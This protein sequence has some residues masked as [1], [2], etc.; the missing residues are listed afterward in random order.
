MI[1][2]CR[3]T[4]IAAVLSVCAWAQY[5]QP[6][7]DVENP[8]RTPVWGYAS[9][10]IDVGWVNVLLDVTTVASGQRLVLEYASV[11]C[12]TDADDNISRVTISIYKKTPTGWTSYGVPLVV[13]KQGN[14]YDG[15]ASFSVSQLVRLYSDGIGNT[16]SID[17]RHSKTTATASCYAVVN[18]Y[19]LATP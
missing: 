14:T 3:V 16:T 7:R 19:T 18:G 4:L 9:G 1:R 11:S 2:V 6:V 17:V 12:T 10:T 15:K 5:S 8:A 13:Q